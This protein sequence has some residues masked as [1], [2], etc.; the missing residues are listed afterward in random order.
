MF[1][2]MNLLII[3]LMETWLATTNHQSIIN[4]LL[5]H[6][7]ITIATICSPLLCVAAVI[8]LGLGFIII[9]GIFC[10]ALI[11]ILMIFFICIA[12]L[13]AITPFVPLATL[14]ELCRKKD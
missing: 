13:I 7:T 10:F 5:R 9:I 1:I 6:V 14:Y 8:V 12:I 2:V 4:N 3:L 11:T